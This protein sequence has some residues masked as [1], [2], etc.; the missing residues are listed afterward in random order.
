MITLQYLPVLEPS[1][2]SSF[3]ALKIRRQMKHFIDPRSVLGVHVVYC[4]S[5][6]LLTLFFPIVSK[7]LSSHN[8]WVA[9]STNRAIWELFLATRVKVKLLHIFFITSKPSVLH[10]ILNSSHT[11]KSVSIVEFATHNTA[12][13]NLIDFT[14]FQILSKSLNSPPEKLHNVLMGVELVT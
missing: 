2:I 7:T 13:F 14:C 1:W 3:Q 8:F 6:E 4:L 12:T 11:N 9:P 10:S 5:N